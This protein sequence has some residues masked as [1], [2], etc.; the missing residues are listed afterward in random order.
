MIKGEVILI[1][2]VVIFLSSVHL[3][4][5]DFFV[6]V[7]TANSDNKNIVVMSTIFHFRKNV[8]FLFACS[9]CVSFS[10]CDKAHMFNNLLGAQ[11]HLG[12]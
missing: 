8:N 12:N 5:T 1:K 11:P 9:V 3:D 7:W 10:T 4:S 6:Q 2:K